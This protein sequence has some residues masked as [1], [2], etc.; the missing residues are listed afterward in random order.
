M[1]IRIPL[2]NGLELRITDIRDLNSRY[3]TAGMQKGLL[4]MD[5]GRNLAEE[6]V[7]FGVPVLKQGVR[8]IFPG[9]AEI[10]LLQRGPVWEIAAQFTLNLEEKIALPGKRVVKTRFLYAL[11]NNTA[12]VIRRI[13]IL[14][15]LLTSISSGLRRL[16]G[17]QTTYEAIS[18]C[19]KITMVHS[20]D[21]GTG[22]IRSS[23]DTSGCRDKN[24]T[25]VIIMNELGAHFFNRYRD[26]SGLV[27]NEK[28]IGC[29]DRVITPEAAF[30]CAK[31]HLSFSLCQVPGAKLFRGRE[32]IGSRL[33]WSG[34]GYSFQPEK[35]A[36]KYTL[37]IE[38][39]A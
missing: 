7:G 13:V 39:I 10:S 30:H 20:I 9:N 23:V 36:L 35:T 27:L 29:W 3:A 38:R 4:L 25:E 5:N 22:V 12:A 21:A 15:G 1:E 14:R 37:C 19:G 11:K 28:E 2:F 33:A 32:L 8:T 17:W 24:T 31:H 16:T 34:F 18:S 26:S 6:A